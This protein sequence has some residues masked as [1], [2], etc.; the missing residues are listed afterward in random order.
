MT[1]GVEAVISLEFGFLTMRTD[2]FNVG[3]NNC[4]LLDSL[5]VAEERR[6]VAMVKM[7]HYQQRLKQRYDKV[8]KFRPLAPGDLVLKKV[9]RT[10]KNPA[11]GKLRLDWEG[12]YRITSVAS[13]RA[14]YLEDLDE[15]VIPRP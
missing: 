11:W 1:Y 14:Y 9:V 12:P 13:I 6:E 3:E 7:A 2:Q 15:N 4:L 5:N 10:T 8:V